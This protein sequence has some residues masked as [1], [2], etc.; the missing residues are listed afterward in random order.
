MF[1]LTNT[2]GHQG[3]LLTGDA[4]LKELISGC[5]H[6][7]A[8]FSSKW[9]TRQEISK[10]RNHANLFVG[11]KGPGVRLAGVVTLLV[12]IGNVHQR[13][14]FCTLLPEVPKCS[15][16][17]YLRSFTWLPRLTLMAHN[18]VNNGQIL[19]KPVPI[20]SPGWDLLI[21]TGFVKIWPLLTK[22]WTIKFNHDNQ[23]KDL[24]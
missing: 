10:T 13:Y 8:V 21:G 12:L 23:V 3:N 22:L 16:W 2:N 6:I 24:R 9:H 1:I 19:T 5:P 20:N 17:T 15:A 4:Y 7:C 14:N 18:F 11:Q